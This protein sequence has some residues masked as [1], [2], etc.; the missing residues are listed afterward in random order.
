MRSTLSR[1]STNSS[2]KGRWCDSV[3][4]GGPRTGISFAISLRWNS[5]ANEWC[6]TAWLEEA[7]R[8]MTFP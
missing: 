4:G 3:F 2:A 8:R 1:Q 6:D 5:Q 7:D